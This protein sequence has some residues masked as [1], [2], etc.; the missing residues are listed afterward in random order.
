MKRYGLYLALI[1]IGTGLLPSANVLA[2]ALSDVCGLYS[3]VDAEALVGQTVSEGVFRKTTFPAGESCRYVFHNN[4]E[5]YSVTFRIATSKAIKEEGI[6][7][8]AADLMKRQIAA[9]QK[10]YAA[11][12]F[13]PLPDLGEDAFWNG[14]ELWVLRGDNLLI[15]KIHSPLQGSF[16]GGEAARKA[17]ENQN[18]NLSQQVAK[19]ILLG[20]D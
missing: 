19:K 14:S 13:R 1:L 5:G 12:T 18:L 16:P 7:D 2:G 11:K 4:G 15:I 20:L 17:S 9:R 10:G 3:R 6:N 8:S